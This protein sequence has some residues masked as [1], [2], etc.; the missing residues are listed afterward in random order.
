MYRLREMLLALFAFIVVCALAG[1][2]NTA[3]KPG[4]SPANCA[5]PGS[6]CLGP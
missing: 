6:T 1:C 5:V 2:Q 3:G 4:Q